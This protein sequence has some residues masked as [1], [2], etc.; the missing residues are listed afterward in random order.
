MQ[1]TSRALALLMVIWLMLPSSVSAAD[2]VLT[3]P[4][5]GDRVL[6]IDRSGSN[7]RSWS[8]TDGRRT[9]LRLSREL[10]SMFTQASDVFAIGEA[11]SDLGAV[12]SLALVVSVPSRSGAPLGYCGA[13]TED[14]L[15][16][17]SVERGALV[18]RDTLL[19]QSCLQSISLVSDSGDGAR[20]ALVPLQR[21]GLI[22]FEMTSGTDGVIR[23]KRV[24]VEAERLVAQDV[25]SCVEVTAHD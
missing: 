1:I 6:S 3:V 23:S 17:L 11:A 14:Y 8:S 5:S 12:Q 25:P 10:R 20:E 13:G 7:A 24:R 4:L 15:L 9:G 18:V 22:C 16:I 21:P 2:N 19:L